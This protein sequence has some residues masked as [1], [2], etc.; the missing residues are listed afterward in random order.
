MSLPIAVTIA[1]AATL[2][3]LL[4]WRAWRLFRPQS[5]LLDQ[6]V[7]FWGVVFLAMLALR[8][9]RMVYLGEFDPDESQMLAQAKR[10]L[11]HPVPWRDVDGT[12]SGPLNSLLL[13][14]PLYFGAPMSWATARMVLLAA[15]CAVL[16]L[17]FLTLRTFLTRP[18]AQFVLLPVI[19]FYA[20]ATEGEFIHYSSEAFPNVLLA[21]SLYLLFKQWKSPG[22]PSLKYGCWASCW[23]PFH[24]PN[25]KRLRSRCYWAQSA[26]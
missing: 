16:V 22:F 20:L 13:S 21:G 24:L 25:C 5:S 8:W 3:I 1:A 7:I 6:P 11:S 12:T 15:N 17:L 4:I 14:V 18:E 19:F 2:L 10:F 9:P 23:G 26:R